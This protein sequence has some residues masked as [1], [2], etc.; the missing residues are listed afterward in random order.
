MKW[1]QFDRYSQ[2]SDCGRYTVEGARMGPG[3]GVRY[4]A[5]KR[6]R[7]P[8]NLGCCDSPDM[9]KDLAEMH[10]RG[11]GLTTELAYAPQAVTL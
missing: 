11:E 4:T 6:G 8:E 1:I 2:E 9:A 7:P 3:K 5:W 10:E